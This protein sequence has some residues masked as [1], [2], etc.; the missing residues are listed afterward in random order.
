MEVFGQSWTMGNAG[1][2]GMEITIRNNTCPEQE[3]VEKRCDDI[4][5]SQVFEECTAALRLHDFRESCARSLAQI[6]QVNGFQIKEGFIEELDCGTELEFQEDVYNAG[7]LLLEAHPI[8]SSDTTRTM[9]GLT[10][11]G[12]TF[13]IFS[14]I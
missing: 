1:W 2:C 3:A 12:L 14:L 5:Q 4:L 8:C 11:K 10:M 7:V 9:R 13:L 6:F